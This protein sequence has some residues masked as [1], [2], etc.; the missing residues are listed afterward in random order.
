MISKARICP[1]LRPFMK[2][3]C[4]NTTPWEDCTLSAITLRHNV[5]KVLLNLCE[6]GESIGRD[7]LD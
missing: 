3:H 5:Q 7:T 4:F 6:Y 2:I 1:R